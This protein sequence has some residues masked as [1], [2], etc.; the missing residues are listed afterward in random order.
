MDIVVQNSLPIWN[1][2]RTD[3]DSLIL[4]MWYENI[5]R[6][7]DWGRS[8]L[9]DQGNRQVAVAFVIQRHLIVRHRLAF[10]FVDH[11]AAILFGRDDQ[12]L[13][14]MALAVV[15]IDQAANHFVVAVVTPFLIAITVGAIVADRLAP[16]AEQIEGPIADLCEYPAKTLGTVPV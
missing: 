3:F 11:F 8:M 9:A 7:R 12:A 15:D 6:G 2:D 4:L 10:E 16:L 13:R 5:D 14:N 1:E